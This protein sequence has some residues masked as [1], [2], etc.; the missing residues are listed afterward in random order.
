MNKI[1]H[2]NYAG[3]Q[4]DFRDDG[5]F[6]STLAANAFGKRPV[7]WLSQIDTAEYLS[8]LYKHHTGNCDFVEQLRKIMLLANSSSRQTKLLKLVKKTGYVKTKTGAVENGGGSWMHPKLAVVFARWLDVDFSIWCDMQIDSMLRGTQN[9]HKLRHEAASSYKVMCN[10]LK[11]TRDRIGKT[12]SPHHFSNESR[13]INWALTGEFGK[14]DREN[15]CTGDLDL[16]TNLE[17]L[18][19]VLIGCNLSYEQRKSELQSYAQSQRTALMLE[20]A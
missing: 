4:F 18:D 3:K 15:L 13:L 1:I 20:V 5:W 8:S 17:Q 16:L 14:V 7:D 10:I 2:I 19:S 9:W 12:S 6:N 11:M